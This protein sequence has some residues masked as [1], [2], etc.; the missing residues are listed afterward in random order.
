MGANALSENLHMNISR[1]HSDVCPGY[2]ERD[3]C[4]EVLAVHVLLLYRK[5]YLLGRISFLLL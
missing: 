1:I 5:L 3:L 4:G 2:G